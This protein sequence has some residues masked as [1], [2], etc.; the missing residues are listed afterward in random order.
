MQW[1]GWIFINSLTFRII[2]EDP[3][4]S[5]FRDIIVYIQILDT[6]AACLSKSDV[7]PPVQISLSSREF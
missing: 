7:P 3:L 5:R 1:E 2:P 4:T 6:M